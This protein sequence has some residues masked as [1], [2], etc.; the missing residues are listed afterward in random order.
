MVAAAQKFLEAFETLPQPAKR[1]VLDEILRL[2]ALEH[3]GLPSDEE[4]VAAAD[5]LF[6]QMD[7]D[8]ERRPLR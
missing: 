3:H 4:L 2:A 1:E 6:L 7:R 8:E 5:D